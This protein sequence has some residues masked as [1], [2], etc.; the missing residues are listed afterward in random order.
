MLP[1]QTKADWL[2]LEVLVYRSRITHASYF[3]CQNLAFFF[4]V[5]KFS[6]HQDWLFLFHANSRT[7]VQGPELAGSSNLEALY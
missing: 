3:I 4:F 1:F 2:G 6:F 7:V 5:W